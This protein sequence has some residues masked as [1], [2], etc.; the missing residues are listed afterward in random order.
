MEC[1]SATS[2]QAGTAAG[3]CTCVVAVSARQFMKSTAY[4]RQLNQPDYQSR[5]IRIQFN[6]Q[7]VE[8]P[9]TLSD[10][11]SRYFPSFLWDLQL[12]SRPSA[13]CEGPYA[14]TRDLVA[15]RKR[16]RFRAARRLSCAFR[17]PL[18]F[19]ICGDGRARYVPYAARLEPLRE[20]AKTAAKTYPERLDANRPVSSLLQTDGYAPLNTF[21]AETQTPLLECQH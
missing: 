4:I 8:D 7:L 19:A 12:S 9:A 15:S 18:G 21:A 20:S 1:R 2:W 17:I 5:C 10:Q 16:W 6:A 14:M 11:S 13:A 3:T